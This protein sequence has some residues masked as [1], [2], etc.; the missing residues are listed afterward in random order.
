[1][2][3]EFEDQMPRNLVG[4]ANGKEDE[5]AARAE[6]EGI[7]EE[8]WRA[9]NLPASKL[10][11]RWRYTNKTIH[12]YER[13][14]RSLAAFNVGPAV[15]AWVR[16]RLEWVRDNKFYEMPSG[17][18][19]LTIDP[20]GEVDIQQEE[21]GETPQFTAADE[22]Q[23]TLWVAKDGEVYTAEPAKH[24]ADTLVRDLCKTLGYELVDQPIDDEDVEVFIVSDEFGIIACQGK[25]GPIVQ[26]L[27]ECFEK[28]WTLD[29]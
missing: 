28:L 24:A 1:M 25:E 6:E 27:T 11:F 19:V 14:L 13:R 15:Q 21:L 10:E 16:S 4:S 29:R 3:E 20:E 7:S 9:Q 2:T 22:A 18:I 17:V 5:L 12:L 23:G 26:K 8:E